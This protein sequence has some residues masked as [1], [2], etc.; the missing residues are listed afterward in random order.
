MHIT[1]IDNKR[2]RTMK[3]P[4]RSR[5]TN[6]DVSSSARPR[7]HLIWFRTRRQKTSP[8]ISHNNNVTVWALR[9]NSYI[10]I[11]YISWN[12]ERLNGKYFRSHTHAHVR[13]T[14]NAVQ[15]PVCVP[16]G[17]RELTGWR[18]GGEKGWTCAAPIILRR[19]CNTVYTKKTLILRVYTYNIYIY[20][21]IYI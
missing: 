7:C 21:Y 3:S 14:A 15:H 10:I 1:K 6:R 18:R 13:L 16:G 9:H 17:W 19:Y 8:C 20:M 11:S 5:K 2:S 4:R 12:H